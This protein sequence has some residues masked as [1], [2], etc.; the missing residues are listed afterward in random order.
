[1][2]R[3]FKLHCGCG[4]VHELQE[5][6]WG[7]RLTRHQSPAFGLSTACALSDAAK[8]FLQQ[9]SCNR[10]RLGALQS[11]SMML[12]LPSCEH[13]EDRKRLKSNRLSERRPPSIGFQ[14]E[15]RLTI[16]HRRNPSM[17]TPQSAFRCSA[18]EH[19][20]QVTGDAPLA[21]EASRLLASA[22]PKPK[23]CGSMS[24]TGS[25]SCRHR[26]SRTTCAVSRGCEVRVAACLARQAPTADLCCQ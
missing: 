12:I 8:V 1:M 26:P 24:C 20:R 7:E 11:L 21:A 22:W 3:R 9:T 2:R 16:F 15:L 23:P 6:G 4:W 10:M 5:P 25:S 17:P 18:G 14:V 13:H 19:W